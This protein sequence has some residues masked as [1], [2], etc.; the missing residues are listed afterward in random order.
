MPE[1]KKILSGYLNESKSRP[2]EK[3][4]AITNTSDETIV[5]KPGQKLFLNMTTKEQRE[6]YPNIPLFSKSIKVVEPESKVD[7][8]AEALVG[9]VVPEDDE[10]PF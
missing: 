7:E 2:G 5:L 6:K 1:Y 9:E 10:I 8:V 4:L 3:Y